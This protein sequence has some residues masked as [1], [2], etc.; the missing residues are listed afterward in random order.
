MPKKSIISYVNTYYDAN[1]GIDYAHNM[2]H[3]GKY[4]SVGDANVSLA[5]NTGIYYGFVTDGN[6]YHVKPAHITT[7]ADSVSYYVYE[8]S[9]FTLGTPMTLV[10]H[11]RSYGNPSTILAYKAPT[12]TSTG[13]L[14]VYDF[15]PGG[16]D[17]GHVRSGGV[18]SF[19]DEFILK[20][21]TKYL[22]Y[23]FNGST[24][25]NIINFRISGYEHS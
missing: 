6:N 10:A 11:N 13:T 12:V 25:T 8:D 14:F 23:F 2:I 16:T 21:S 15:L 22:M 5:T 18:S 19:D 17:H 20:K 4:Y 7:S 9:A 24:E 1:V 3:E